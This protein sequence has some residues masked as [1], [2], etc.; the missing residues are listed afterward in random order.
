MNYYY[1]YVK[2]FHLRPST[3]HVVRAKSIEDAK[4]IIEK[5]GIANPLYSKMVRHRSYQ[6]LYKHSFWHRSLIERRRRGIGG[7]IFYEDSNGKL[8]IENVQT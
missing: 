8:Q 2:Y 3:G 1:V 6:R 4:R 7:K 5:H